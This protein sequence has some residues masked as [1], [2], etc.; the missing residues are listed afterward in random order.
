MPLIRHSLSDATRRDRKPLAAALRPI[1]AAA[2]AGKA[3][4]ALDALAAGP[5]GV[6][7]P[8]IV[9]RWQAAWQPL[10]PLFALP[11]EVRRHAIFAVHTIE[12]LHL[13]RMIDRHG[14][15]AGDSAATGF[16]WRA[17]RDVMRRW[18]RSVRGGAQHAPPVSAK[19]QA[20]P[21]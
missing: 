8:S 16:A 7:Y 21:A 3:Q 1:H 4:A 20:H 14:C 10:F 5:W 19:A 15:F 18:S 2:S 6:K 11:R 13:R 17:Q 9:Q 12:N